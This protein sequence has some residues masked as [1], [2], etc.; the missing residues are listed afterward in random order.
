M[1]SARLVVKTTLISKLNFIPAHS[2]QFGAFSGGE[3][4]LLANPVFPTPSFQLHNYHIS[5]PYAKAVL[6]D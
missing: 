4:E 5:S 1:V 6:R 3:G 2:Y